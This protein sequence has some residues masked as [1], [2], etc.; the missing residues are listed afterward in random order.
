MGKKSTLITVDDNEGSEYPGNPYVISGC[1]RGGY[2]AVIH[3]PDGVHACS[4][5]N[6]FQGKQ[7]THNSVDNEGM[8]NQID[9]NPLAVS[10]NCN[11]G[12]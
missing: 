5:T 11:P 4:T 3:K 12:T 8:G 6:I 1:V 9:R 10:Q 7:A 2:I